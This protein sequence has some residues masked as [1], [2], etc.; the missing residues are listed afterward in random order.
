MVDGEY[1]VVGSINLDYRSLYLHFES[2]VWLYRTNSIAQLLEDYRKCLELC[3][4][5]TLQDV[6]SVKWYQRLMRSVLRVF[7]PLM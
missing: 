2:A 6:R 1:G 7:A 4:E 3:E 5:V